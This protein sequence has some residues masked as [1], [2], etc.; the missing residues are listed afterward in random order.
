MDGFVWRWILRR[1][2]PG[3]AAV[4]RATFAEPLDEGDIA[5]WMRPHDQ[6]GM[7]CECQ[8]TGRVVGVCLYALGRRS[9]RKSVV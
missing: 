4:E 7:L 9:D 8:R 6:I 3:M 2:L 5:E 1:D